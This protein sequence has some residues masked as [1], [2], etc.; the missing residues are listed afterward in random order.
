[1]S[2]SKPSYYQ[3]RLQVK[4]QAENI[5]NVTNDILECSGYNCPLSEKF[6]RHFEKTK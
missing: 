3:G 1:M 2:F 6:R 5:D 4:S